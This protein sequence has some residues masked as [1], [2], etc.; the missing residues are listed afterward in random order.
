MGL[1]VF[2][3][4]ACIIGQNYFRLPRHPPYNLIEALY[5]F[6]HIHLHVWY[7][8]LVVRY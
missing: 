5:M 3:N 8:E 1:S 2:E 4:G 7:R 6:R